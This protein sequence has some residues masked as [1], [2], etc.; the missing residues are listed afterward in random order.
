[1]GR[2]CVVSL[3]WTED[4]L[5]LGAVKKLRAGGRIV[6]RTARCGAAG[7]LESQKIPFSTFDALYDAAD[8][9]DELTGT[10][11][12]ALLAEAEKSD[13]LFGV[14]DPGDAVCFALLAKTPDAVDLAGGVSEGSALSA[15]AGGSFV[16]MNAIDCADC[17]LDASQ[18]ALVREIDSVILAG[19]VKLRLMEIYP[20]EWEIVVSLP[21]GALRRMPLCELDRL[22]AY[23]HRVCALVP[24]V[25]ALTDQER[26]SFDD[27]QRIMARLR[28]FDGCPWDREQTHESLRRYLIEEAYE[29]ADAID[30]GD[31]DALCDELGDVLL[32]VAFHAQ[33]AREY[34]EFAMGDVTT[35][36]CRKMI[37]R[38][39]H[40]FRGRRISAASEI[41][42]LWE[43]LKMKE[44]SL[45]TKTSSL[46][47]VA[48]SLPALMRAAKVAGKAAKF[49]APL[50]RE[51]NA[52]FPALP[53]RFENEE[54][55]GDFLMAATRRV[56][57]ADL[58]PELALSKAADRLTA[59]FA[60]M[61]RRARSE[62]CSLEQLSDD[63]LILRWQSAKK[64]S[65]TMKTGGNDNE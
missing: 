31:M 52:R 49:G 56:W 60:A 37:R 2:I 30:G 35:A 14:N 63:E 7:W 50:D 9:F 53:D 18:A 33:I 41:V 54:A 44:R 26:F 19:D 62:G 16:Q 59:R 21:D 22:E 34:G 39:P 29:V 28:A 64:N 47:G 10:I 45:D 1:M 24:A 46:E 8:D 23:D 4:D 12:D 32:Q 57:N 40:V 43:E 55:A 25:S 3:G 6:L 42:G 38:H 15:F 17:R 61:E 11:V 51:L 65:S 27:L 5:T 36:I 48:R 20:E 58:D 13:V